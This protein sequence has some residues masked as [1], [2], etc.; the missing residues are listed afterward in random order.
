MKIA[1]IGAGGVGAPFGAALHRSGQD[2]VFVARGRHLAA[3]REHG[4]RITGARGEFLVRVRATDQPAELGPVDVVLLTV[5]LWDVPQVAESLGSMVGPNSVVVTLQNGI[6]APAQVQSVIGGKH[7][8]AGACFVNA[9]ISEP[10]VVEQRSESQKIVAGMLDRSGSGVL[11]DFADACAS[12]SIDFELAVQPLEAL[13]EK[14]AQLVP[15]SATTAL[16]RCSI[17]AV[18]DDVDSWRFFLQLLDETVAVGRA[19]GVRLPLEAIERR[20]KYV[21]NMPHEATASMAK[22][23]MSGRRLELPWLSGRVV[24]LGRKHG[25]ATPAN[26]FANIALK[27]FAMGAEPTVP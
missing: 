16:L 23:L 3:M 1:I 9:G 19:T 11:G 7:V 20:L 22:D 6:D 14:F 27:P 25:I 13:W 18:R 15:I 10:G 24:Q 21:K 4:L 8:A 12:S 2:V 26:D 5:K 17:G